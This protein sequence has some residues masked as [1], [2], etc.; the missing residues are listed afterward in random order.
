MPWRKA[1]KRLTASAPSFLVTA[2]WLALWLVWPRLVSSET[3]GI[4][5][6]RVQ[7]LPQSQS[8]SRVYRSPKV[9]GPPSPVGFSTMAREERE[10]K[11]LSHH[12]ALPVHLLPRVSGADGISIG[13][14]DVWKMPVPSYT[15]ELASVE[16][17]H[18]WGGEECEVRVFQSVDLRDAAFVLPAIPVELAARTNAS[19]EVTARVDLDVDGRV[20]HVFLEWPGESGETARWVEQF[21]LMGRAKPAVALRSGRVTVGCATP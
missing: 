6:A 15:P 17:E 13:N 16:I 20:Q 11:L 1:L 18:S 9:F 7:V 12:A 14:R 10:L 4:V 19:W 3:S 8:V 5:A 21:L 2:S